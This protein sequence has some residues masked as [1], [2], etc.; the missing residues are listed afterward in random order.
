M[1]PGSR[2]AFLSDELNESSAR[3]RA[4]SALGRKRSLRGAEPAEG[5]REFAFG[6]KQSFATPVMPSKA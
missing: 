6:Q 3:R 4:M 1:C 2:V 5:G